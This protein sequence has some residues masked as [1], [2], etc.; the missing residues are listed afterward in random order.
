MLGV[1][2][3]RH[4]RRSQPRIPGT[5]RSRRAGGCP[6]PGGRRVCGTH[7]HRWAPFA[8]DLPAGGRQPET[9]PGVDRRPRQPDTR[10]DRNAGEGG[11]VIVAPSNG[12]VHPTGGTYRLL[13]GSIDSIATITV[14]ERNELLAVARL[15]TGYPCVSSGLTGRDRS[16]PATRRHYNEDPAAEQHA[17]ELLTGAGWSE[18]F[19]RNGVRYLR[20]PGKNLGVSATFGYHPGLFYPFTTSTS[21]EAEKGYTPFGVYTVLQHDGDWGEAAR[22]L[23]R[24]QEPEPPRAEN[25]RKPAEVEPESKGAIRMDPEAFWGVAGEVVCLLRPHTEADE[26][27]ILHDFLPPSATRWAPTRSCGLIAPS[28][29]PGCSPCWWGTPPGPAKAPPGRTSTGSWG[30]STAPG[31]RGGSAP[32]LFTG[33]GLI[34][35]LQP[36]LE[37]KLENSRLFIV[38]PEFSKVLSVAGRQGNTLSPNLRLAWDLGNLAT[39]TRNS[40]LKAVGAHISLVCHITAEELRRNLTETEMASGF[41]NRFLSPGATQ[42]E[43]SRGQRTRP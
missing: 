17:L 6:P 5:V 34:E 31:R 2:S 42:P 4:R 25:I 13:K 35:A 26:A 29:P 33:E 24:S 23:H 8:L 21:F 16:R 32:G 18:V 40:P 41:A 39:M 15:S 37:G 11:F 10:F 28:T 20:R 30:W 38:E 1:R 14:E 43:A 19:T 12:G 9:G 7:P 36:D 27:A 22:T 3:G